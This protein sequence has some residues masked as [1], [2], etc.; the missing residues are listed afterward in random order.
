[1]TENLPLVSI[2]T[3]SF[4]QGQF[5]ERTILSVLKQ[6]YPRIEY[7]ILDNLSTDGTERILQKYASRVS[8]IVREKDEGQSD[9]L[10]KGFKMSQGQIMAYLNADDALAG[11]H[12]VADAVTELMGYEVD[13]IYGRRYRI[14]ENG[15]FLDAYPFREFDSEQLRQFNIIPQECS[16]WTRGI[17]DRAGAFVNKD[18]HF[19]MDYEMWL[20]FLRHGAR[21]KALDTVYGYFRWHDEQKSQ[22]IWREVC[23]PEVAKIQTEYVGRATKPSDMEYLHESYYYGADRITHGHTIAL[24]LWHTQVHASR[25]FFADTPLD[26]WVYSSK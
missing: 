10:N 26:Q 12:I 14:D 22:V 13:V 6:T 21:F 20:R 7:I 9:C 1:M 23:L 18:L 11:P 2:I 15:F 19:S 25:G 3:P 5:I 8:A 24:A 4:N 17:Y 16:F